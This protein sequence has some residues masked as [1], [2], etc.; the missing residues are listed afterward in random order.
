M[1]SPAVL[2]RRDSR[3]RALF[4]GQLETEGLAE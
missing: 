4:A 2:L 1:G 3:C